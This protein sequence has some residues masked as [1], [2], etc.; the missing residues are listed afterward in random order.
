MGFSFLN[1]WG[2]LCKDDYER[3]QDANSADLVMY[4]AAISTSYPWKNTDTP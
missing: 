2:A 3:E 4:N 1:R